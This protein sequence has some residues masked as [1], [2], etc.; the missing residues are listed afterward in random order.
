MIATRP[1][2]AIRRDAA[3]LLLAQ[4]LQRGLAERGLYDGKL[5]GWIGDKTEAALEVA[6]GWKLPPEAGQSVAGQTAAEPAPAPATVPGLATFHGDLDWVHLQEGHN[7]RPYW[8]GGASGVTL[9]P[10][11]DLGQQEASALR[12]HYSFLGES[13]LA[14]LAGMIGLRGARARDALARQQGELRGVRVS[15]A[16]ASRIF[17][18]LAATYWQAI[19]RR[20]PRLAEE[21]TPGGVQTAMLSLSYNRGAGNPELQPLTG[22]IAARRWEEV[23]DL[24]AGLQQDH[25]LAGI[26][27][28]RRAEA[29][30]IRDELA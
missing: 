15:R 19:C 23:A 21:G 26:P 12:R 22:P 24:I 30:L 7:G 13:A 18:H 9:D 11:F 2:S 5:D 20:F 1:I 10:G 3:N 28:R 27:P 29:A 4:R 14:V 8:P 16:V 17:P 25:K 6:L